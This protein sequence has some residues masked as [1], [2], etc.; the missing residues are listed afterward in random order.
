MQYFGGPTTYSDERGHP[1]LRMRHLPF[2]IDQTA[3]DRWMVHMLAALDSVDM[4]ASVRDELR[5]YFDGAATFLI[6][7]S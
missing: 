4:P 1:R 3:R 6:N 5:Q 2:A 7:R